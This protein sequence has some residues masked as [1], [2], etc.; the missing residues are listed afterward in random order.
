M[1]SNDPQCFF[2]NINELP[3]ELLDIV[4]SFIPDVVSVF[5]NKQQYLEKHYLIRHFINKRNIEN[6]IRSMIRQDND[7]V[8]RQLLAENWEKW[9]SMKKCYYKNGIYA[10][11]LIFVSDYCLENESTKCRKLINELLE[12][13]GLSKNQHKKNV[14]KYIRWKT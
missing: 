14:I 8:F 12:E 13:Q 1:F 10:N 9:L 11:Y 5:L 6:Y 4:H 2:N 7:F 3:R